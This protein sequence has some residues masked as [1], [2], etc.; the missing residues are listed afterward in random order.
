MCIFRPIGV[1]FV[2]K[3]LKVFVSLL[4][5]LS[6][7]AVGSYCVLFFGFNIDIFDKSGWSAS[8][9][10]VTRYLDYHGD[11]LTDWQLI[12]GV[13]YYFDPGSEGAMVTGW[14]ELNGSRYY[15]G[16][17]GGRLGG[18]FTVDGGTYYFSP[19]SGAAATGWL[20]MED[21]LY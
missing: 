18:W 21:S 5:V 13:W 12:D 2:K 20:T 6:L 15:L 17:D 10:G 14:L 11:P 9:D 16:P 3:F 1:N 19:T 4:L 8:E 7:L